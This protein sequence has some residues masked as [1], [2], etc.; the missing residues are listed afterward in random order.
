MNLSVPT[1]PV[2]VIAVI[3]GGIGILSKLTVIPSVTPYAFWLVT[4][5][6][7]LLVLGT[8]LKEM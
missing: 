1:V 6:F 2:W 7:L 4:I 3:L 5:G 8:L